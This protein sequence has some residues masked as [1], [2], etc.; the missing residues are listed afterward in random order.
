MTRRK[1][2]PRHDLW[3]PRVEG[4][5]RHT[6]GCHPEWFN[7]K[8]EKDKATMVNSLAKRIVGEIVAGGTLVAVPEG[9]G[10]DLSSPVKS[11]DAAQVSSHARSVV[12]SC[13]SGE[14]QWVRWWLAHRRESLIT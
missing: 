11:E 13:A 8:D 14:L 6:I 1:Q 12:S 5:I 10:R 7:F 4:Q 9:D 3:H 2:S